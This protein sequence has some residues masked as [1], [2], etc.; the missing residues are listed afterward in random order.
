MSEYVINGV[1]LND[2]DGRWFLMVGT[3][4]PQLGAMRN[5][6]TPVP[7]RTGVLWKPPVAAD[8]FMVTLQIMVTDAVNGK[9]A[10]RSA[11]D[12][13]WRAFQNV[14]R[15]LGEGIELRH[16]PD[17]APPRKATGR[18]AGVTTPVFDVNSTSVDVTLV[19]ECPSGVWKDIEPKVLAANDLSELDGGT[20]PITDAVFQ[21]SSPTERIVIRD[22]VSGKTMSW[23]GSVK[24]G[25]TLI[26][27]PDSYRAG[28]SE[29]DSWES[30]EDATAG[31]S[32]G[33]GGF[34]ITPDLQGH[35]AITTQGGTVTVK[36]GRSY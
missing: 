31:L 10:G 14:F 22:A 20:M 3:E 5:V 23:T 33:V 13:N 35:H 11:L 25:K 9:P 15:R 2:A 8:P 28:W 19:V 32:L 26:I 30:A 4:L 1:D 34:A 7:L 16:E 21:V 29:T 18:I 24:A 12:A 6:S 17:G 36:A 27:Q